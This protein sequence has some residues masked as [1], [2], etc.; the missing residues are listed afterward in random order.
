MADSIEDF[1]VHLRVSELEGA[2]ANL[3]MMRKKKCFSHQNN[4]A[5]L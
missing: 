4:P 1:L 2:M 3:K 5:F